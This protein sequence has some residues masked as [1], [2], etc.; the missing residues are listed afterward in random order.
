MYGTPLELIMV[1]VVVEIYAFLDKEG[2]TDVVW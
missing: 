2:F 1:L